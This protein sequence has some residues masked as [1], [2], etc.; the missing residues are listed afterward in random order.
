MFKHTKYSRFVRCTFTVRLVARNSNTD[1]K[2]KGRKWHCSLIFFFFFFATFGKKM[3]HLL[4]LLCCFVKDEQGN[5]DQKE[6]DL[7]G[8]FDDLYLANQ[9]EKFKKYEADYSRRLMAKYFSKKN[10][11]GGEIFDENVTIDGVTIKASRSPCTRAYAAPV[12]DS[13]DQKNNS[14]NTETPS[15]ISNGKQTPKKNG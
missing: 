9:A 13:E 5:V 4:A 15:N 1:G 14:P 10:L 11:Y 2:K 12:H 8:N 3:S 7:P 6:S